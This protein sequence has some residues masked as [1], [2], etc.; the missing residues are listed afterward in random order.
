MLWIQYEEVGN[1]KREG[2]SHPLPEV[3][4]DRWMASEQGLLSLGLFRGRVGGQIGIAETALDRRRLNAFPTYRTRFRFV[5]HL[6]CP[7]LWSGLLI[8]TASHRPLSPN[9]LFYHFQ[10]SPHFLCFSV[11]HVF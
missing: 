7:F 2:D 5:T 8:A 1:A 4:D 9:H 3:V 10:T 11:Y 6:L